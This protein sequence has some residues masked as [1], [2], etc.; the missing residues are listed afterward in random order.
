MNVE[1]DQAKLIVELFG[2]DSESGFP[3]IG[4]GTNRRARGRISDIELKTLTIGLAAS[5]NQAADDAAAGIRRVRVIVCHHSFQ[6]NWLISWFRGSLE[7]EPRSRKALEYLA[8]RY[9]VTAI[10]T[11]HAHDFLAERYLVNGGH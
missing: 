3:P 4:S 2:V 7:L 9:R 10:L 11:G 8:G 6:G 5:L 1:P